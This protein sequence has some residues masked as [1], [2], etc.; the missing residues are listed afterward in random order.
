MMKTVSVKRID[1][2]DRV[3]GNTIILNGRGNF[4]KRLLIVE[5]GKKKEYRLIRS[6]YGK[7]HL[8]K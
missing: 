7:Y 4:P 8:N 3:E 5:L 1:N 2:R 6:R